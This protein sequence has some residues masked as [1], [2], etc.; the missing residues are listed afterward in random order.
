MENLTLQDCK[1]I[2]E[3]LQF[4]IQDLADKLFKVSIGQSYPSLD[5]ILAM[6]RSLKSYKEAQKKIREIAKGLTN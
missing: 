3:G 6:K 2:V 5:D 4:A 1:S